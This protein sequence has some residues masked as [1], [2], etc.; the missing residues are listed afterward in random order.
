MKIQDKTLSTQDLIE[1]T[2][3]EIK[4]LLLKKNKAYGDSALKP[5]RIFSKASSEEQLRVR[6]DDKISRIQ[7]GENLGEDPILDLI[8]YLILLLIKLRH[9]DL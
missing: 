7:R 3:N 6:I 8:G 2:C 9:L 4:E 1:K 5:V